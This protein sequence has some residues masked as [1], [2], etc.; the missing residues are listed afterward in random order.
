MSRPAGVL[1]R[2]AWARD[3]AE[4]ALHARVPDD[5]VPVSQ[6]DLWAGGF[7]RLDAPDEARDD[8]VVRNSTL[9]APA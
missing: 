1:E 3:D 8:L 5:E 2:A 4:H 9:R 6:W 7:G